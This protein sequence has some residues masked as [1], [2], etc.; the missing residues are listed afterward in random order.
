M[1][2][3]A[4]CSEEVHST[5][6]VLEDVAQGVLRITCQRI[7]PTRDHMLMMSARSMQSMADMDKYLRHAAGQALTLR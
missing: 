7:C 5:A 1:L 2:I 6:N 3:S 4:N